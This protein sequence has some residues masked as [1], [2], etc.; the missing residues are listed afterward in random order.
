MEVNVP[1]HQRGPASLRLTV[2]N[3]SNRSHMAVVSYVLPSEKVSI[4]TSHAPTYRPNAGRDFPRVC[5]VCANSLRKLEEEQAAQAQ[6]LERATSLRDEAVERAS[7]LE[8]ELKAASSQV[9][10]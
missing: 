10:G 8:A 3:G 9:I 2:R 1:R 6:E 7:G 5:T 4:F